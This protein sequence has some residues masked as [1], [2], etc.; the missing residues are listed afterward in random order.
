MIMERL[1]RVSRLDLAM[2]ALALC[3]VGLLLYVYLGDV[4]RQTQLTVFRIDVGVCVVFAVEFGWRW[5]RSGWSRRFLARNWYEILGM[6]PVSHPALRSFRLLRLVR[7][8]VVL[9]RLGYAADRAFGEEFTI[10]LV[11]R[12][13]D[14]IVEAIKRPITVAVLDEVSGV[15]RT[16]HYGRNLARALEENHRPLRAMVLEKLKHDPTTRH[17]SVLPFHDRMVVAVSDTTLRVVQE[18]LQD[19]RT[20]EL[21]AD[22]LRENLEQIRLAVTEEVAEHAP[23]SVQNAV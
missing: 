11:R 10:R 2:L 3:S 1:A 19:P 13:T 6:I 5:H 16:G 8:V 12:F 22:I 4:S 14:V 18:V 9:V 15:L 7:V 20:D 21:V 17:L 23:P